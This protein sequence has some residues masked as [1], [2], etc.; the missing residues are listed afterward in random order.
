MKLFNVI[1]TPFDDSKDGVLYYEKQDQGNKGNQNLVIRWNMCLTNA[2]WFFN[3]DKASKVFE[4]LKQ[5]C[6]EIKLQSVQLVEEE[7]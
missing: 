6:P 2:E 3:K 7:V 4:K 1:T 5:V